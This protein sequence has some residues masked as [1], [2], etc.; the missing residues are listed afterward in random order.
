MRV[1]IIDDHPLLR[2]A[3]RQLIEHHYPSSIVREAA[4]A[5]EAM[6]I[7][8]AQPVE[9]MILDIALPD[10]SGLTLLKHIKQ[11]RPETQ[12]V[13]LS[14]H[15]DP[16]YVGLA[17][18]QGASGYLTK[19]SAPEELS[20]AM[21]VVLA[22]GRYITE[23]LN[24]VMDENGRPIADMLPH[25]H[26]SPRELEVLSFLAKGRTVSQAAT[27]L[28]LSVKTVSTYRTR[29]LEKLRLGTTADLIRYA[30]DHQLVQ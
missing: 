30:I 6:R 18:K 5:D 22:G 16:H 12:C 13:I 10:Q 27:R 17:L 15:E 19:E 26:L 1:L 7:V 28:K 4:N 14:I 25:L 20:Q 8:R 2:R 23:A 9:L 24:G 11:I 21:K 29:L 3:V